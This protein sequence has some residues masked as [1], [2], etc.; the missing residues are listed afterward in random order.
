MD[1]DDETLVKLCA[2]APENVPITKIA[3]CLRLLSDQSRKDR[4]V[5]SL[6]RRRPRNDR[7]RRVLLYY[8]STYGIGGLLFIEALGGF[9]G[10]R[11]C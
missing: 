2:I 8:A 11:P 3:R 10:Q 7:E 4:L 9:E 1:I 5:Q 6:T